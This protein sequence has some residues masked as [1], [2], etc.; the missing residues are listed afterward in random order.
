MVDLYCLDLG[1]V[2]ALVH[3]DLEALLEVDVECIMLCGDDTATL[4]V[5]E[6]EKLGLLTE[7]S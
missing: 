3:V 6:G 1:Y 2:K 4:V 5:V 7:V